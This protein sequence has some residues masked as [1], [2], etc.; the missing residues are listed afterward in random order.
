[1]V[2]KAGRKSSPNIK[3]SETYNNG[4]YGSELRWWRWGVIDWPEPCIYC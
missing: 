2:L 1:M 4:T 3:S